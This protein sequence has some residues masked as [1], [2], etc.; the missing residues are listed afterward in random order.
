MRR[1]KYTKLVTICM[2]N[3]TYEKVRVVVDRLGMSVSEWIRTAILE[4]LNK[5]EE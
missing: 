3:L 4:K 5:E 1:K 2:D